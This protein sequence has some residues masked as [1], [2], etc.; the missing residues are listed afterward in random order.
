MT[1]KTHLT[2]LLK[3]KTSVFLNKFLTIKSIIMSKKNT[4]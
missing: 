3:L 2:R 1:A 4:N